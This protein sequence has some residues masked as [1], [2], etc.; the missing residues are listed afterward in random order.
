MTVQGAYNF[1]LYSS[2]AATVSLVLFTQQDLEA[3]RSTIEIPLDVKVN[4][5]GF[6]WHIALPDLNPD[7]L[8]GTASS[9]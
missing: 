4:R 5:T 7:L 6:A 8:Y 2:T 9:P 1:V 3:G